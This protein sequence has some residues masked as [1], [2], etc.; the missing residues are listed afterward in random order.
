MDYSHIYNQLITRGQQRQY[1][2]RK[3][4]IN[5][6]FGY[7]ERHHIVPKSMGGSN[8]THNLVYLT[9]EEHYLA[10]GLLVKIHPSSMP[11]L[12]ALMILSG[13]N[14]RNTR[15]NK[16]YGWARRR[17][18]EM[19]KGI[20]PTNKG[21]PREL[22]AWNKGIATP[23]DI[24]A[25][26]A[27]RKKKQVS[28]DGIIYDSLADAAI[29]KDFGTNYNRVTNRCKSALHPTWFFVD[30]IIETRKPKVGKPKGPMTEEA[31]EKMRAS[32]HGRVPWNKGKKG[33]Q[34]AWNKGLTRK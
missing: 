23:D 8:D 20:P 4:D 14:K 29:A 6:L 1:G 5:V 24:C 10:H 32:I 33:S 22:P 12:K 9:P 11:L 3:K 27:E 26:M 34:V 17:Y 13:G 21:V 18:A 2:L 15:N 31:K 28:I 16:L 30:G 19:R 7:V 25:K